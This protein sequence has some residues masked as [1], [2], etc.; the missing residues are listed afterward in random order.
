MAI[1]SAESFASHLDPRSRDVLAAYLGGATATEIAANRGETFA[2]VR[3]LLIRLSAHLKEDTALVSS[4]QR[5]SGDGACLDCGV[6]LER[7]AGRGGVAVRCKSC[8][9]ARRKAKDRERHGRLT[10]SR[11]TAP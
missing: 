4:G 10:P 1:L 2:A 8:S 3:S 9:A 11:V 5:E 7:V 6:A